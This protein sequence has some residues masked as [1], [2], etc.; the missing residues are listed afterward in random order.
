MVIV[1][2]AF[3]ALLIQSQA[4]EAGILILINEIHVGESVDQWYFFCIRYSDSNR[5]KCMAGCF[6]CSDTSNRNYI[7]MP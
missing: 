4:S 5:F 3:S 7:S 1:A 2:W 6:S